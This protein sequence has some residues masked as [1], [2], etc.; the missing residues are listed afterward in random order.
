VNRSID[1]VGFEKP[2]DY[3]T[4]FFNTTRGTAYK[5]GLALSTAMKL[6]FP[7]SGETV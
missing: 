5:V 6:N 2:E 3:A 7:D 1:R 4:S